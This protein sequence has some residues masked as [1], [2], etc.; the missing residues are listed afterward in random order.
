MLAKLQLLNIINIL[1]EINYKCYISTNIFHFE[2]H[3]EINVNVECSLFTKTLIFF[4]VEN[5]HLKTLPN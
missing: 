3:I 4:F 5:D 1:S 2:K